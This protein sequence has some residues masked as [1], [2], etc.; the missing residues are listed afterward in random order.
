MNNDAL[1]AALGLEAVAAVH[2]YRLAVLV[3]ADSRGLRLISQALSEVV[4]VSSGVCVV[5]DPI[6]IRLN[7][8]GPVD[9]E[10]AGST[11]AWNPSQGWSLSRPGAAPSF[12]ARPTAAPL[13][14]V[15][16]P[17]QLLDWATT[18]AVGAAPPAGIELDDDPD[19]VRR[20]LAFINPQR[21]VS[22]FDAFAPGSCPAASPRPRP[23][24]TEG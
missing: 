12:Y 17:A 5:T 11:L 24:V 18:G 20:L 2:G 22:L 6:D 10:L 1:V 21:P 9:T 13:D 14:L 15:P 16:T 19:T 3:E 7:V 4:P 23:N 8:V